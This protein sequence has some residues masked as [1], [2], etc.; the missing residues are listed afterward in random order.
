MQKYTIKAQKRTALGRKVKKLRQD[1][2]LPANIFG[3]KI[4][5]QAVSVGAKEFI[6]IFSQTGETVLLELDLEGKKLPVLVNNVTYHPVT[7]NSLHVD[8]H[9]VDLK[10]KVTANVPLE[11]VGEPPAVKDKI[12]VLLSNISEIEVEALPQDLPEKIEI[13]VSMLKAVDEAIKVAD[14]K[15]SGQI[16]ILTDPDQ[17]VVKIAPLVSKEAEKMVEE[18]AAQAAAQAA[19]DEAPVKEGEP[20]S[21]AEVKDKVGESKKQ[22]EPKK[23]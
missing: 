2:L 23:E 8:F 16:K 19:V 20:T 12:G 3:N 1:G 5:S 4:K 14:L 21:Q 6:K 10:E 9:Q 11:I 17:E 15:I 22:E 13:D 18:Q 7:G